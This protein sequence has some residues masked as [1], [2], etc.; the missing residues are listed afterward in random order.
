MELSDMPVTQEQINL[1][2]QQQEEI[3]LTLSEIKTKL[4]SG[5]KE[6]KEAKEMLK[7]LSDGPQKFGSGIRG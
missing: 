3:L 1:L 7:K 4:S 6:N 2:L 5:E